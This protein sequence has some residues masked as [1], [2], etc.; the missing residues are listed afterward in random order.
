MKSLPNTLFNQYIGLSFRPLS[1]TV[2]LNRSN[3]CSKWKPFKYLKMACSPWK[4]RIGRFSSFSFPWCYGWVPSILCPFS[5]GCV[6]V[7]LH[8][9][10]SGILRVNIQHGLIMYYCFLVYNLY[11]FFFFS[12][13]TNKSPVQVR[14]TILDAWGWCTGMTQRIDM[15]REEGGGFRIGNTCIRVVDSFWYNLYFFWKWKCN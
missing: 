13:W 5:S 9:S 4:L 14:C 10:N 7:C 6:I 15:R 12:T 3:F 1:S 2:N 11:F 8:H